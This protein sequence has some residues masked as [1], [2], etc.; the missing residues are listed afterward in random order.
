MS[1]RFLLFENFKAISGLYR[2]LG[3]IGLDVEKVWNLDVEKV[4]NLYLGQGW[5]PCSQYKLKK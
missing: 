1:D 4:W 3:K 5:E 2:G